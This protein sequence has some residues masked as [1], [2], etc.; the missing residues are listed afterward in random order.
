MSHSKKLFVT[1]LI[2]T[3]LS[4]LQGCMFAAGA[5]TGVAVHE[6]MDEKGYEIGSPVKKD[7]DD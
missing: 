6:V 7:D 3:S 2:L 1:L 5:A 4:T